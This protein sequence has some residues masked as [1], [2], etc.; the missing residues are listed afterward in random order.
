MHEVSLMMHGDSVYLF[1]RSGLFGYARCLGARE[2]HIRCCSS[3]GKPAWF[4]YVLSAVMLSHS[5][6]VVLLAR[7]ALCQPRFR[8]LPPVNVLENF[9]FSGWGR[10]SSLLL[11]RRGV[12]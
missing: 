1:I 3:S 12:V 7:F 2:L 10:S 4:A 6:C 11:V 5:W 9:V 8:V